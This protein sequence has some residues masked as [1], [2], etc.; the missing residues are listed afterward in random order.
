VRAESIERGGQI[1][2]WMEITLWRAAGY[3][4]VR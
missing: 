4:P 2:Q 1:S 3:S